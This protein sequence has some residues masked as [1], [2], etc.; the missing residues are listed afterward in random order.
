MY[1]NSINLGVWEIPAADLCVIQG[2]SIR[3]YHSIVDPEFKRLQVMAP[4][5]TSD[6]WKARSCKQP[7]SS[8]GMQR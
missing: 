3:Q 6:T 1:I 7:L 8:R 5:G 2:H 4:S